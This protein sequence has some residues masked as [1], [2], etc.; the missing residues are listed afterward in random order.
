MSWDTL[1]R[2]NMYKKHEKMNYAMWE[3]LAWKWNEFLHISNK[4]S[5]CIYDLQDEKGA[6]F[7]LVLLSNSNKKQY[8]AGTVNC[9]AH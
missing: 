5:G 1:Q 3:D 8:S 2:L 4:W 6:F 9:S 7:T